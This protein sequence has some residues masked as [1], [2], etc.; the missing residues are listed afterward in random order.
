MDVPEKFKRKRPSV[1][2][3]HGTDCCEHAWAW[4]RGMD[5][6]L[7]RGGSFSP[8]AW[9]RDEFEWGPSIWPVYWCDA[10]EAEA[11]DCGVFAAIARALLA[12]RNVPTVSVQAV[13]RFGEKNV[14]NWRA[15]WLSR[16]ADVDW[17]E[18]GY[19]YHETVGILDGVELTVW[20]PIDGKVVRSLSKEGYGAT[21]AVHIPVTEQWE[22][23]QTV[24]WEDGEVEVGT[25]VTATDE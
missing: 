16:G 1:M 13:E 9:L 22:G 7:R 14:E 4:F 6:S 5:R 8:P 25:W 2:S 21:V 20:D 11:L 23:P 12:S 18:D 3:H 19:S 10:A 15:R 24:Q 17:V